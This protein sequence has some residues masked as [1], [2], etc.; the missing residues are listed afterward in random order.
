MRLVSGLECTMES[1]LESHVTRARVRWKSRSSKLDAE[2]YRLDTE[3]EILWLGSQARHHRHR[4]RVRHLVPKTVSFLLVHRVG[5]TV[6][7]LSLLSS[8]RRDGET[9]SSTPREMLFSISLP[10]SSLFLERTPTGVAVSIFKLENI[11]RSAKKMF[12][13]SERVM[14]IDMGDS[15]SVQS[16]SLSLS[17][18]VQLRNVRR[19][20]RCAVLRLVF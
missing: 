13:G 11:R 10:P 8:V 5:E 7:G 3:K 17:R 14:F 2:T 12:E 6:L 15:R 16:L 20:E 4:P 19:R 1:V 9:S 18:N